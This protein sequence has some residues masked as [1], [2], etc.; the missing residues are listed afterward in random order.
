MKGRL[1]RSKAG[2]IKRRTRLTTAIR[3]VLGFQYDSDSGL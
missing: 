2:L 1:L 3:V